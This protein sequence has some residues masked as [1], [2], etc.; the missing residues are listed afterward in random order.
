MQDVSRTRRLPVL[1]N[2][3]SGQSVWSERNWPTEPR[4]GLVLT[5]RI[6]CSSLRLR[7]SKPGYVSDWHVAGD[8]TLIIVQRG[9]LG[10]ELRDASTREFLPGEAFIAADRLDDGQAFDDTLHGHRARV[11]SDE[12]LEA[13]HIKLEGFCV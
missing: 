1:M 8:A 11:I 2:G 4:G 3:A 9:G 7:T 10:L 5:P 6:G 13:V 12:N